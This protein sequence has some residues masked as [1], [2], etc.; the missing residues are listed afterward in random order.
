MP[1]QGN[2]KAKSLTI[3]EDQMKHEFLSFKKAEHH[4]ETFQDQ[5]LKTMALDIAQCHR[6]RFN[7][8]FD[9]LNSHA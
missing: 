4:A 5:T 3:L 1:N 6:Q 2:I 9:Y 7:R 8:L